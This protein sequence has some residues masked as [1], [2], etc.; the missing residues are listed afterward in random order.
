MPDPYI[1]QLGRISGA[2]LNANLLRNGEDLSF[3]NGPTDDDLLYL[4]VINGRIGIN[5]APPVAELDLIGSANVNGDVIVNGTRAILDNVIINTNS[6]FSTTVGPLIIAPT[7][8]DAYV[9][10]GRVLN[11]DLELKDNF[12]RTLNSNQ[13]LELDANGTGVVDILT[14]SSIAGNLGVTGNINS[15]GTVRLDGQFIIGDS[16]IDTVT[17]SPDFTQSIIPGDTTTYDL[18]QSNKRWNDA[19]IDDLSNVDYVDT[20][21]VIISNQT[22]YTGHTISTIQSNEDLILDSNTGTIQLESISINQ[23]TI[24]NLLNSNI[25][26][27]HTGNGYLAIT[28]TSAMGIPVGNNSERPG[29]AVGET[30]WNNQLGYMECFDGTVW[31]VATGG[32]TVVTPAVMEELGNVY[33]LIFG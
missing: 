29:I 8:V 27:N 33:T 24:T 30:R 21:S 18:G 14:S 5:S 10:Y 2:L 31:Q 32:G 17:I 26:I 20:N 12:I 9:E 11:T 13:N 7:G 28:D 3:R 19:F 23:G 1:A 6:T 15:A 22:L 25:V 16:P 4:D